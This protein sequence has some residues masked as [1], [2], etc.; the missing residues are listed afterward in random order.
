MANGYNKNMTTWQKL[1]QMFSTNNPQSALHNDVLATNPLATTDPNA[2][3]YTAYSEEEA[4]LKRQELRQQHLLNKQWYRSNIDISNRTLIGLSNIKLMY[5]EVELMDAFP[6]IGAALDIASEESCCINE[7]GFMLNINSK[8]ERIRNILKDLFVNRLCINTILP[9]IARDVCKYGN[10]FMFLNLSKD[11]GVLGWRQLPVHEMERYEHGMD[12]PYSGAFNNIQRVN[13]INYDDETKF[14]WV[15]NHEGDYI[16]YHNWQICHFRL[17]SDSQFLPYGVSFLHKARRHWRMLSMMEDMMLLYRLERSVERRVFKIDV[18]SIDEADVP[19]YVQEIA[20]SFKRTPVVDPQTGQLDLKKNLTSQQDDYFIPVRDPNAPNPIETLSAAQ[21]LTALDDVKFIQNKVCAALR[22][23]KPFLNFEESHGDGKNLSL[24]DVRFT[25]TINRIQQTLLMELNKVA[26]IHLYLLGFVDELTNFSLTMNNPS[27]QA[28][29]LDLEN[30]AKKITTAKDA[31][32]DPGGGIPLTSMTWAWKHIMKWSDQEIKD[33]LEQLR[34]EKALGDELTKTN[35]IIQRTHIFDPVDNIYGESGAEY[36]T[37]GGEEGGPEGGAPAGGGG[38]PMG[39]GDMD[40]GDGDEAIGEEG[41]MPMEDAAA[42]NGAAPVDNAGGPAPDNNEAPESGN[43]N[44]GLGEAM[45]REIDK[46]KKVLNEQYIAQAK[47]HSE[48]LAKRL[49]ES[50]NSQK[51]EN[52]E[53][54]DKAFLLNQE[55]DSITKNLHEVL[56]H[57]DD[58]MTDFP[59]FTPEANKVN[60]EDDK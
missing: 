47:H 37:G 54:Y 4:N 20:N 55:M 3:V 8:S 50:V 39:G 11:N 12:N 29:M 40:F 18:G 26:I 41:E 2:V 56:A 9:M 35:Q 7:N 10:E 23:P 16:P 48:K 59:T 22:V 19:A 34:L 46:R 33:N 36:S 15:G 21:N 58:I 45:L 6:E 31:V 51:T 13:G 53:I 27:S 52:V 43:D 42:E 60:V 17:L 44:G 30:M 49:L 32:S 5:R 25:R 38:L 28:E 1:T 24:M 57:K 14:V